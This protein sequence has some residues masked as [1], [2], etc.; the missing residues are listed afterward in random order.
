[1]AL[2]CLLSSCRIFHFSKLFLTTSCVFSFRLF[3]GFALI[4]S[5]TVFWSWVDIPFLISP[6][7]WEFCR[8]YRRRSKTEGQTGH[9]CQIFHV[10]IKQIVLQ[11]KRLPYR[12]RCDPR[13]RE[14]EWRKQQKGNHG[15]KGEWPWSNNASPFPMRTFCRKKLFA[16]SVGWTDEQRERS[17]WFSSTSQRL[18]W[19]KLHFSLSFS[20]TR[21]QIQIL[22]GIS[23]N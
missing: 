10:C 8:L 11:L 2:V 18:S 4:S 22:T 20:Y 3:F 7:S 15:K 17:A 6:R 16:H 5:W 14:L 21:I 12:W 1:M 19:H 9:I 23:T 13:R